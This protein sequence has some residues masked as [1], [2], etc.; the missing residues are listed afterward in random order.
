[1][2]SSAGKAHCRGQGLTP[3]VVS[4]TRQLEMGWEVVAL[5]VEDGRLPRLAQA[6]NGLA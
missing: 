1:M 5:G 4:P 2:S 3:A 6:S